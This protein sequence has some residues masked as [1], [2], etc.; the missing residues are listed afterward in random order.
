MKIES[1]KLRLARQLR[2]GY[3]YPLYWIDLFHRSWFCADWLKKMFN[4]PRE[5]LRIQLMLSG[6]PSKEAV[7]VDIETRLVGGRFQY[8]WRLHETGHFKTICGIAI[9]ALKRMPSFECGTYHLSCYHWEA[10]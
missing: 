8:V 6:R 9:N 10:E 3:R 7:A 1:P 4:I 2:R 5:A